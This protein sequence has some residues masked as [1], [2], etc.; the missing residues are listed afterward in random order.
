MF[1]IFFIALAVIGLATTLF[2]IYF[3]ALSRQ[4]ASWP[5]VTGHVVSTQVRTD[6]SQT[7]RGLSAAERARTQR[8]YPDIHYRWSV[9]GQVYSGSRYR[10]GTSHE[11]FDSREQAEAAAARFPAQSTLPVYYDPRNPAQAVLDPGASV[12]VYAPLPLGLLFLGVGL[13][14]LRYL[15]QLQQAVPD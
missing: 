12:G 5:S 1:K 11:K 3:I 15:P 2:G 4:A 8:Y 14:G 10:L 9:D 13:L 7:D 6:H